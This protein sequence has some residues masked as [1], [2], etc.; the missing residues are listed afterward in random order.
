MDTS[1]SGS[2]PDPLRGEAN[3]DAA[4]DAIVSRGPSGALTL[5]G[6]ATAI[7]IA[8]WFVFYFVVFLPRGVIQ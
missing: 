8:C 1:L 5:A 7:V 3:D 6:I 2:A 4:V